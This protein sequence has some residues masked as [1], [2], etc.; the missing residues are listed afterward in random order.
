M[1]TAGERAPHRL[2]RPAAGTAQQSQRQVAQG[3][4]YL[5]C[6][7]G[8][9]LGTILI[10]GDIAHPAHPMHPILDSPVAPVAT[11]QRQQLC[12]IRLLR[13]QAGDGRADRDRLFDDVP[14][15]P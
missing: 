1:R 15:S 5:R 13:R 4:E 12:G 7:P 10:E 9:H 11:Q 2:N 14:A 8:A 3:G 6:G